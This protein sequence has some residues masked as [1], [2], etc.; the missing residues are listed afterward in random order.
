M[1]DKIIKR[2]IKEGR[3]Y[4]RNSK[5]AESHDMKIYWEGCANGILRA[6]ELIDV[7]QKEAQ[8]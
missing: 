7:I 1:N 8:E 3:G 2:L 6:V 4:T 5:T